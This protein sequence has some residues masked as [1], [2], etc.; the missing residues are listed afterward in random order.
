MINKRICID[1]NTE[2]PYLDTYI[3][4]E[5]GKNDKARG[6]SGTPVNGDTQGA[7]PWAALW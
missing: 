4:D 2:R 1:E 6:A 5:I 7:C 3:L